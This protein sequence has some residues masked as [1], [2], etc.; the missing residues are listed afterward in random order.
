MLGFID[1]PVGP[2]LAALSTISQHRVSG[3]LYGRVMAVR[4]LVAQSLTPVVSLAAGSLAAIYGAAPVIQGLGG[5][6]IAGGLLAPLLQLHRV[7]IDGDIR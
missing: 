3:A 1:G 2:I 7:T 5:L 4:G 6:A